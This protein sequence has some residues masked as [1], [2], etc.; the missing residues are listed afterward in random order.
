MLKFSSGFLQTSSSVFD[1]LS[2]RVIFIELE[3]LHASSLGHLAVN[4]EGIKDDEYEQQHW[5]DDVKSST[6]YRHDIDS[7]HDAREC[8]I[9]NIYKLKEVVAERGRHS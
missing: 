2:A 3:A 1:A 6:K 7:T 4:V 8:A 5:K 9:L